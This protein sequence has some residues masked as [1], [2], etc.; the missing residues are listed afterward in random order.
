MRG[1]LHTLHDTMH[2]K[3]HIAYNALDTADKIDCMHCNA[4]NTTNI[5][6]WIKYGAFN[7]NKMYNLAKLGDGRG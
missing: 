6:Q 1:D 5:I 3:Q 2:K 4:E 7:T